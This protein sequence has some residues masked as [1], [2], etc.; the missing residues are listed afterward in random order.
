[1]QGIENLLDKMANL[2]LF[3]LAMGV[4]A[5]NTLLSVGGNVPKSLHAVTSMLLL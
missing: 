5:V 1:M 4:I 2:K 3:W